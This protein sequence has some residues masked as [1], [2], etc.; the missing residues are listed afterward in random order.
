MA[1]GE[2]TGSVSPG[3]VSLEEGKKSNLLPQN[4]AGKLLHKALAK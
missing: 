3:S 4:V 1:Q 2:Q